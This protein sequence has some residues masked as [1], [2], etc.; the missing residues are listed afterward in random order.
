MAN[1]KPIAVLG[2]SATEINVN[3]VIDF[4]TDRSYDPNRNGL[5]VKRVIS[6]DSG[7]EGGVKQI[8]NDG[9][10]FRCKGTIVGKY[11][12]RLTVTDRGG[13]T[14][15]DIILISVKSQT[16]SLKLIGAHGDTIPDA[17]TVR[18]FNTK[19]PISRGQIFL[20]DNTDRDNHIDNFLEA[21][22]PMVCNIN[23][24][25]VGRTTDGDK[26]PNP[27][28]ATA[29]IPAYKNNLRPIFQ[30][31]K[32]KL[33]TL[34]NP[35]ID[36]YFAIEN[37]PTQSNSF[38]YWNPTNPQQSANL[39]LG[40]CK[41]ACE[42]AGEAEFEGKIKVLDGGLHVETVNGANTSEDIPFWGL[43]IHTSTKTDNYADGAVEKAFT[44]MRATVG[45]ADIPIGS[46]EW[47]VGSKTYTNAVVE[48]LD[49]FFVAGAFCIIY[50]TGTDP[51]TVLNNGSDL[52]PI[53]RAYQTEITKLLANV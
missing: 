48:I 51:N 31:Y 26:I 30:Y 21:G 34:N 41:A 37:E 3:E 39:Y 17:Q 25:H 8:S 5:I 35:N 22:V 52:T 53:G 27:F 36:V 12:I 15:T 42:V 44:K 23:N 49:Q 16:V 9:I 4:Y 47:H 20:E 18:I 10:N 46:N 14:G 24:K 50:I 45:R 1:L 32:N 7:P 43:L 11:Q 6:Q 29:D 40:Q 38:H 28:V 33:D 13:L 19:T 2:A